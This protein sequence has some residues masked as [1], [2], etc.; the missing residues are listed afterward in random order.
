M[1][2]VCRYA[3]CVLCVGMCTVCTYA[4]CL[5]CT[6]CRC[7]QVCVGVCTV[8]TVC[9][10]LY[11][12][13]EVC[14][15]CRYAYCVLC[16][17]MCTVCRY[18]YCVQVCVLCTV[19]RY[20]N[21]VLCVGMCIVFCVQV[22]AEEGPCLVPGLSALLPGVLPRPIYPGSQH[23]YRQAAQLFKGTV[24]VLDFTDKACS[25]SKVKLK[26]QDCY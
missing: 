23:S 17:G 9:R 13:Q 12:V 21:C 1:R 24:C 26:K 14:T 10:Y 11:C 3:Y 8:C 20:V 25:I 16:V 19:C 22:C 7:V 15:V 4:Y 5:L 2:T 6:V 18:V